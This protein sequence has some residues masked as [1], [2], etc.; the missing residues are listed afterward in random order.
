MANKTQTTLAVNG[1]L[2]DGSRAQTHN[3]D[4]V[5]SFRNPK[6]SIIIRAMLGSSV[7]VT[8]T[9]GI[10]ELSKHPTIKNLFTGITDNGIKMHFT[11][12]KI[13]GKLI[14]WS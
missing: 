5:K 11:K 10:Y 7:T 13:V 8:T 14:Y 9:E 3:A 1:Y 4:Q 12:K 2:K 6:G